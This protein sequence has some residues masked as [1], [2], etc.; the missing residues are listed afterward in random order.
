MSA[1]MGE[2]LL[3]ALLQESA[4]DFIQR[5]DLS[6]LFYGSERDIY[7][8]IRGHVTSYGAIP[9]QETVTLETKLTLPEAKEPADYYFKVCTNRYLDRQLK[10]AVEEADKHLKLSTKL[11]DPVAAFETLERILRETRIQAQSEQIV[12][13][14]K[15]GETIWQ[16]FKSAAM[17]T[18]KGMAL[19]WPYL[20]DMAGGVGPGDVVSFVGRPQKGKTWMMLWAAMHC[21]KNGKVPLFVSMEMDLKQIL[22]RLAA[23][24]SKVEALKIKKGALAATALGGTE[25]TMSEQEAFHDK[26]L[27]LGEAD[28][29][30]WVL[31]GNLA[32]TVE[33][34]RLYAQQLKPDIIFIDGAYLMTVEGYFSKQWERVA[35]VCE[36]MKH[37]L[38]A[39]CRVPVVAS[40]QFN[41]VAAK[42]I[43]KSEESKEK[44]NEFEVDLEDIAHSDAIGQISSLVLGFFE[45]TTPENLKRK[46][47]DVMKGRSGE[48]GVFKVAWDFKKMSFEQVEPSVLPEWDLAAEEMEYMG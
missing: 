12:D 37:A 21:W 44:K 46:R 18:D 41:R 15:A 28:H 24:F 20:D 42:K 27:R 7:K 38:A 48:Q 43:K 33:D 10:F 39:G 23:L 47:V 6:Y 29:P 22:I 9:K 2:L 36:G 8:V 13:F 40:F 19:G 26:L 11:P 5:G 31:D 25:D 16:H 3:S 32:A 4:A 34:I 45:E 1:S 17:G 35:K 14:T 30:F